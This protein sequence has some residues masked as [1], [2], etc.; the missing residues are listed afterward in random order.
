MEDH[1]SYKT[2]F[3]GSVGW[4]FITD[5]TVYKSLSFNFIISPHCTSQPGISLM[6]CRILTSVPPPHSSDTIQ[7]SQHGVR[8]DSNE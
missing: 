3:C 8:I 5:F 7:T 4:S 2:T 1:L 6:F